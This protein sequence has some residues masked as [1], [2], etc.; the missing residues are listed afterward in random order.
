M[1]Q[2]LLI[3]VLSS[4]FVKN[5]AQS[6]C[7]SPLLVKDS[8]VQLK[9][10]QKESWIK[11]KAKGGELKLKVTPTADS[12][13]I[14]YEIYPVSYCQS[15][16]GHLVRPT[17]TVGTGL[18]VLTD[19]LWNYTLEEGVCVCDNCLSK[20]KLSPNRKLILEQ[21]TFYLMK[22]SSKGEPIEIS[23]SWFNIEQGKKV[24]NLSSGAESLEKNM[25]FQLKTVQFVASR[26]DFLNKNT[27]LELDSLFQFLNKNEAVKVAIIGHV[28][29][30]INNRPT[31]FQALSS[32]RAKKIKDYLIQKGIA[33]NRVTSE[34]RSNKEMRFPR[35]KTEWEA[36]QNRRVE[37]KILAL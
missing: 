33:K 24:F 17:R 37:V 22:V 5:Y 3:L 11:F 35:P 34:G 20:V 29:G 2:L 7:D 32:A 1:K 10:S 6:A 28:N 19:E 14:P 21:E 23:F 36:S 15:I 31:H 16:A 13:E 8:V 25:V 27:P 12:Q 18:K 30:P 4:L 9:T 26:T